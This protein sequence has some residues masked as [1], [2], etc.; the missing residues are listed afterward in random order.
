MLIL[1][2]HVNPC[3]AV[4]RF[5]HSP[6]ECRAQYIPTYCTVC[7]I[8]TDGLVLLGRY[9]DV[10]DKFGNPLKSMSLRGHCI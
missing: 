3:S 4:D 5:T 1:Y 9:Q 7:L 8:D 10:L 2:C 6:H